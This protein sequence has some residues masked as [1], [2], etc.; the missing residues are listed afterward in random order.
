MSSYPLVLKQ[1]DGFKEDLNRLGANEKL[2]TV[3][4]NCIVSIRKNEQQGKPL[5]ANPNTGDL[6]DC[7]KFYIDSEPEI[8]PRYRLVYRILPTEQDAQ[9][10]E[11]IAFGL[12]KNLSAYATAVSR[13]ER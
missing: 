8:K 13:L 4:F 11:L 10:L 1:F 7:R 9:I 5:T 3:I 12:R 6:S 2:K